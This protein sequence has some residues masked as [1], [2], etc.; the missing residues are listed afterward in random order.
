M[1]IIYVDTAVDG[2]HITYLSALLNDKNNEYVLVLPE[3]VDGLDYKQYICADNDGNGKR[4]FG[5]YRKWIKT[6]REIA[7]KENPDI[8]HFLYGDGF[9][10]YFGFGL[11][12]FKKY[13]TIVTIHWA[14]SSKLEIISTRRICSKV[15]TVVV[16]SD[17][18]KNLMSGYGPKNIEHIEY[19]QFNER[20]VNKSD[21][22]AYWG[23]KTDIPTIACIGH[24]RH[25][26]GLDLLLDALNEVK[27]PFQLLV[28]GKEDSFSKQF[29]ED[30]FLWKIVLWIL[31]KT[32]F[33]NQ[34]SLISKILQCHHSTTLCLHLNTGPHEFSKAGTDSVSV[35]RS[36]IYIIARCKEALCH[37]Q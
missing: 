13:K 9:Y 11:G 3:K 18:I 29:I 7:K 34:S 20:K 17:Y 26:K 32:L 24:T 23:L 37:L 19:P 10:R 6:I 27:H 4:T 30:I 15:N 36:D 21:A 1:K 28:A 12:S 31:D 14:R 16:H 35:I 5:T 25:D 33:L 22:C 2:H 8:I